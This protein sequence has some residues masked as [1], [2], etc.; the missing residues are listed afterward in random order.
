MNFKL[1]DGTTLL[2]VSSLYAITGVPERVYSPDK[3]RISSF[4]YSLIA[5]TNAFMIVWKGPV[6]K[7]PYLS[8]IKTS[9][10]M[11]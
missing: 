9:Q 2:V 5:S 7:Y 4:G 1:L 3:I 8:T 6:A 10:K 11:I